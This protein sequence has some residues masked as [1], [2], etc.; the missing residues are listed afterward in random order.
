LITILNNAEI[1]AESTALACG[2]IRMLCLSSS[3]NHLIPDLTNLCHAILTALEKFPDDQ[4]VQIEGLKALFM[5]TQ[6]NKCHENICCHHNI[7]QIL[8]NSKHFLQKVLKKQNLVEEYS[9]E[10]IIAILNQLHDV[11]SKL[12]QLV[13]DKCNI[14]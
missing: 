12:S 8:T 9:V 3:E 14:S 4:R 1:H 7:E 11:N 13:G 5:L 2:A 10:E 6:M